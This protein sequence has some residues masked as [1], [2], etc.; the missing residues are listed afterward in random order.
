MKVLSEVPYSLKGRG[1]SNCIP[2][3]CSCGENFL[4]PGGKGR[5]VTCPTC[6]AT[7]TFA[8]DDT[9]FDVSHNGQE[10]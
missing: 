5:V 2:F 6:K 4:F 7:Q 1:H 3:E 9:S 8:D 10:R